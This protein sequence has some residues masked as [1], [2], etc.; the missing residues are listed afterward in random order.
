MILINLFVHNVVLF[1]SENE[2]RCNKVGL[3]YVTRR[4]IVIFKLI[5]HANYNIRFYYLINLVSALTH[6][7]IYIPSSGYPLNKSISKTFL[8]VIS[9]YYD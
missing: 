7:E 3:F 8:K 2:F 1:R 9:Q 4:D 5:K 6:V